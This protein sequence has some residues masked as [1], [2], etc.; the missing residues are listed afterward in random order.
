[1]RPYEALKGAALVFVVAVA[2][3]GDG[4]RVLANKRLSDLPSALGD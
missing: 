3:I 2:W 4:P 1:M